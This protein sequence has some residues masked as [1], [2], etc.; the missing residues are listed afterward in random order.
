MSEVTIRFRPDGASNGFGRRVA[1]DVRA[2]RGDEGARRRRPRARSREERAT[3]DWQVDLAPYALL[4]QSQQTRPTGRVDHTFVYERAARLGEARIRLR[5]TVAGDELIEVAPYVH[6]PE[7]FERRFRELRSA[8]DTIAGI[9]GVAA[10]LLYGL[11]GC[12][13]GVLWLARQHWLVGASG[14][15]RRFRRRRTDGA[16]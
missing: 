2:R 15:R 4:E 8:N 5:L 14:A 3:A 7:S 10:G 16:R 13:L 12:I 1:G 9:A 6:V 11:G